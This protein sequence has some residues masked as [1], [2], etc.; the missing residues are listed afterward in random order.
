MTDKSIVVLYHDRC[1]DGFAGAWVARKV[2][3][4]DAIYI[5]V[6]DRHNPPENLD[7]KEVYVIDFS[8]T[9]D[10][11]NKLEENAKRLVVLDHHISSEEDVKNLKEY[12]FDNNK[13]GAQI[14]WGYFFKEEPEPKLISYIGDSDIWTHKL[15]HTY[16]IGTYIHTHELTLEN[17]DKLHKELESSDGFAKCLE[18]GTTLRDAHN[19]RVKSF[20]ERA[21]D[22]EFEGY[23]V[24][25]LN[26]PS[27][28]RS[29]VGNL[30][31]QKFP[32]FAVLFYLDVVGGEALWKVSLRG[33]GSINLAEMAEKYGGGGHFSASAFVC[34]QEELF[35]LIKIV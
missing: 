13:S 11:L 9:K 2:F 20:S 33:N 15:P 14:A 19:G 34:K 18:L 1:Y 10:P 24:K 21:F 25:A 29:D 31:A 16:E 32:P 3:G 7:G 30:L 17:F 5:P 4:D 26:C 6:N 28:I 12:V 27:D 22:I 35:K 23:K 8:F